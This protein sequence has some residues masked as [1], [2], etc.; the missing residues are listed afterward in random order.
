MYFK[1][2]GVRSKKKKRIGVSDEVF[3]TCFDCS[4]LVG[5][6]T[7]LMGNKGAINP[8]Q[9]LLLVSIIKLILIPIFKSY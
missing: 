4:S 2:W 6:K 1:N 7:S 8:I 5:C 9:F 3:L